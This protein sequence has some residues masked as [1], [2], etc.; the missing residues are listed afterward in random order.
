MTTTPSPATIARQCAEEIAKEHC[1]LRGSVPEAVDWVHREISALVLKA[2]T[3]ATKG[4][5]AQWIAC[6][7]RLPED[8]ETCFFVW[9]GRVQLGHYS[10]RPAPHF[11]GICR[12]W[13]FDGYAPQEEKPTHWLPSPKP[14]PPAVPARVPD[15]QGKGEKP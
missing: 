4:L 7:D 11:F 12:Y 15:G 14:Q 3:E 8:G 13:V 6:S 1:D 9:K 10:T 2:I 5:E